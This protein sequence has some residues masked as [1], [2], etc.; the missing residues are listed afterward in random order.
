MKDEPKLD[1]DKVNLR[2]SLSVREVLKIPIFKGSKVIAGKMKL[3]NE[4]KHITILETPEGIEWLEGGEFLLSTGY[5][6]KDD[7]GALENVIYRASKQNVSAIAIKEKRYINYIPQKMID[8]ANEYGVPLIMLPYNFIYTKALTSF[9]N[10][11]MYKKNSYIYESQKMHDKLLR[12]ILENKNVPD[13]VNALSKLTNFSII[14]MDTISNV[15]CKNII[16]GHKNL[17]K[18]IFEG[19]KLFHN[20]ELFLNE[21]YVNEYG[22][23]K[24]YIYKLNCKDDIIGYMYVISELLC[25][26]LYTDVI[27]NGKRILELKLEKEKNE[28]LNAV[29]LNKVITNIILN[30]KSLPDKFY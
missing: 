21:P 26:S 12:L 7:K 9:Y 13:T 22:D 28:P 5:A 24:I 6:F 14:I 23:Y 10:A 27:E 20:I 19:N 3:Q 25:K 8:Q 30:S 18:K 11:L 4:C 29:N 15:I 1:I 17:C 2:T 16:S